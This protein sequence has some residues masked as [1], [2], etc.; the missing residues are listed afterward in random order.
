M[1]G[2]VSLGGYGAIGISLDNANRTQR[3]IDILTAQSS[4]GLVS[5]EFSGLGGGAGTA[6]DL[7]GQLALNAAAQTDTAQAS[8]VNQVAQTAL[9]QIQSLVSSLSGQ[10]LGEATGSAVGLSTLA[11]T[12]RGALGQVAEL[13]NTKVGQVYVFAG[14]DSRTP[15][16][17]DAGD[18]TQSAFFGAVAF[19]LA[20]LPVSGAA[21]VQSQLLTAS[22]AGATSPFSASLEASNRLSAANLGDGATVPLAVLADQNADAVSAGSG[23]TSTGSYMRDVLMGFATLA[24]LGTANYADPQTQ[25]MLTLVHTTLSGADDALNTDIGGLGVRQDRVTAAQTDLTATATAL[26]TQLG[27]VQDVDEAT[28][29]TKLSAA[30]AQLQASYKII[31][32][33]SQLTLAKY[34]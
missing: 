24:S 33:L 20:N 10:L 19:A 15:P 11:A 29:A 16:V 27:A 30:Q 9:G 14:Q 3:T 8:D 22:A 28:V 7:T 1:S 31:S 6:L 4:S 26:T 17:P 25:A 21:A 23:T 12:A 32:D 34:L 13:L 18:I 2:A 5:S